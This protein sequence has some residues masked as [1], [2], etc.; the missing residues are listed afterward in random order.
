MVDKG[1]GMLA[2]CTGTSGPVVQYIGL[3]TLV[4]ATVFLRRLP[5]TGGGK[6]RPRHRVLEHIARKFQRLPLTLFSSG[7]ADIIGHR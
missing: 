2:C 3:L 5:A 6:I 1:D 4:P 7:T